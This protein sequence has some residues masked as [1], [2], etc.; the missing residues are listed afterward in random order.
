MKKLLLISTL[1]IFAL[2][3][4][5]CWPG[6][7]PLVPKTLLIDNTHSSSG[8]GI[9]RIVQAFQARGY[10]VFYSSVVGFNPQEYGA[11]LI[12]AP[13]VA[14]TNTEK[15]KLGNLLSLGG[16]I[17]LLSEWYSYYNS[18]P[19]NAIT[20]YLGVNISFN[21]NLILDNVNNYKSR[22]DWVTTTKFEAHTLSAG[23]NKIVF[24][25]T[26]TLNAGANT[27]IVA[28]AEATSY[29]PAGIS[30]EFSEASSVES[31]V[32]SQGFSSQD[33]IISVPLVVAARAGSGKVVAL[34]DSDIFS[35]E[36]S[37]PGAYIDQLDNLRLLQNIINW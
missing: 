10:S 32:Q 29:T 19:L 30:P 37:L 28:R 13:E 3:L 27:S 15:S 33:V 11:V 25:A 14:Y 6:S 21:N 12:S 23:M 22:T 2:L 18:A 36:G 1:V 9:T 4:T 26:S 31:G 5:S 24:F 7:I 35:G 34:G 20:S 8:G 17:I 16:K